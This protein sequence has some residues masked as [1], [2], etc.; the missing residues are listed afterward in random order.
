MEQI[1][2]GE[3]TIRHDRDL[4]RQAYASMK[5]GDAERCGCSY[6]RNFAAQRDTVYPEAFRLFL[7]QVCID[8]VKEGEVY[9]CGAEGPLWVYCG[10]FY[11]AGALIKPGE[12]MTDPRSGFQ[13]WLTD[14]KGLPKPQG[15]FGKNVL[16]VQFF[17][18]LPWVI[19]DQP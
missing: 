6:C 17:T 19:P 14:A 4:T 16:A 10:W 13:Y 8:S 2:L 18:R 3:Y 5:S 12:R 1:Q 11:F 7:D 15:D 9:D